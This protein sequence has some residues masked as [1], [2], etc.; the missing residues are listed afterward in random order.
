MVKQVQNWWV[1]MAAALLAAFSL[2]GWVIAQTPPLTSQQVVISADVLFTAETDFTPGEIQRL[3]EQRGSPLA[4]YTEVVGEQTLSAAELFWVT[5]QHADYG[6]NPRALL[7]TLFLE[8]NLNWSQPGGLYAHLKQIALNLQRATQAQPAPTT[9]G[10]AKTITP[11]Q[12]AAVAA[13]SQYYA[14]G[15]KVAGQVRASL[16][17]WSAAYRQLFGVDPASSYSAKSPATKVPFMRLPFDQPAQS[18]YPLEAYFDHYF[19]GQLAEPNMLRTDGQALPG[20][21]YSG[22]WRAMT[23][24]SGHNASDFTLPT[25]TPIYAA[26]PGKVIYR[27]DSEGGILIDHGNGYRTTYWHMDKIIVNWEQDV[28]DGELLGWSGCRGT[29]S[30]PH[31]HFG[32]RLTALSQDVDP[33]GWWSAYKDPIPGSSQFMWRGDLLADNRE[34]QTHLFYDQY[35]A[36]EPQG[37]G[38]ESWY[39][40]STMDKGLS[41]NWGLWGT[42]IPAAGQYTVSATWPKHAENTTAAVYQVW[43]AGGMTRV[44]VNQRIEG[45]HFVPLGTFQFDAGPAAVILTDLTT[46]AAKDQRVYFDAVRWQPE[47]IQ[48]PFF[49]P[50]LQS[51]DPAEPSPSAPDVH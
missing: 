31:L 49:I 19:P 28:A 44:T 38:G 9:A 17:Q 3:L 26:A 4:E 25:G 41:T 22:C 11:S 24:Y 30:H 33:F 42:T 39:T 43:H 50:F 7:T 6:Y 36:R 5:S 35:W 8:D 29:C 46:E 10:E 12:T 21:H 13:L 14:S 1:R 45:D 51:A 34:A 37:Y 32:L 48:Q 16:Q 27:L 40:H 23:C 15:A 2:M 18:F 47:P 20:A